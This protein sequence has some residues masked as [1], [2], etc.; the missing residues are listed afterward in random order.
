MTVSCGSITKPNTRAEGMRSWRSSSQ[1]RIPEAGIPSESRRLKSKHSSGEDVPDN[2]LFQAEHASTRDDG[3]G[4]IDSVSDWYMISSV[5]ELML[6]SW[7]E[8]TQ[9]VRVVRPRIILMRMVSTSA[10][11]R[12][13]QEDSRRLPMA[14]TTRTTDPR[15]LLSPEIRVYNGRESCCFAPAHQTSR[16]LVR[17]QASMLSTRLKSEKSRHC[18]PTIATGRLRGSSGCLLASSRM[19]TIVSLTALRDSVTDW[20]KLTG[21]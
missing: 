13:Y 2:K 5:G 20:R 9:F 21:A 11:R 4:K 15:N 12:V 3:S 8:G 17:R 18:L 6:E 1:S 19:H 16:A 10:G 14:R 7:P